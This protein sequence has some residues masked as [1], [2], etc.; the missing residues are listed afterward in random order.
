MLQMHKALI[1]I[2]FLIPIIAHANDP[3]EEINRNIWSFN[4]SLDNSIAKPLA[5]FYTDVLPSPVQSGI[6]NFFSNLDEAS[7]CMQ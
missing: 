4:E 6:S 2:L 3:F 5:E 7:R 1:K